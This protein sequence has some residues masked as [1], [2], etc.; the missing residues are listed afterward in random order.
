[1]NATKKKL[2]SPAHLAQLAGIYLPG[3]GSGSVSVSESES[4]SEPDPFISPRPLTIDP[5]L[6]RARAA[7]PTRRV[8]HRSRETAAAA[9]AATGERMYVDEDE[10]EACCAGGAGGSST[11]CSRAPKPVDKCGCFGCLP[12]DSDFFDRLLSRH[13]GCR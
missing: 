4:D 13:L 6:L 11:R 8:L 1:V 3:R 7:T 12:L 10:D 5:V 9:A 2:T